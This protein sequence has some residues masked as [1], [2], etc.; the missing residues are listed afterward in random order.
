MVSLGNRF[1][2]RDVFVCI[3]ESLCAYTCAGQW[4]G[5]CTRLCVRRGVVRQLTSCANDHLTAE[6]HNVL[7]RHTALYCLCCQGDIVFSTIKC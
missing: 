5:E 7:Q 4:V 6:S 3:C 1:C 2:V